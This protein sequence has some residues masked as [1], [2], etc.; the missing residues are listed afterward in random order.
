M[1]AW[2]MRYTAAIGGLL[3]IIG[4]NAVSRADDSAALEHFEKRIRPVLVEHCYDCHSAAAKEVKGGLVVDHRDGLRSGGD[5]GPAIVPGKPAESLLIA[6]LKHD[7][8]VMPPKKKLSAVVVSDF[9]TWIEQGAVDPRDE[10]T[11]PQV[12][13]EQARADQY[14]HRRAWWSLQP[15]RKSGVPDVRHGDWPADEIDR[16]LLARLEAAQLLPSEPADPTTLVRRLSF[17]LTGLP[18]TPDDIDEF[19]ADASPDAWERLVDRGLASPHFGERWAR[20]WMDIV[21]YTDTYGY[22]WDIPAKGAWRYRDYLIR[23]FNADVPF[24]Q[25][26]REQLA[27]DLLTSPRINDVEQINESLIGPMFY[28]LGEKRHGDSSEFDGI[29]QEMLDNKV[30][31]CSKAFL[32]LTVSCARCHDHK[33]DAVL[34]TEYYAIGGSFM[35]SRWVAN[36]VDLPSRHAGWVQQLRQLKAELKPLLVTQWQHDL[37]ATT[38][39]TLRERRKASGEKEPA[40][41]DPLSV[42]SAMLVGEA[43]G[44]PFE[45]TW[46]AWLASFQAERKTRQEKNAG[47]FT[48]LADFRDGVPPGW[49]VDGVGLRDITPRGDFTV[50]LNGDQAVGQI[51]PGGLFTFADSPRLNGTLRSPLLN[52]LEPG[53]LSFEVCGGEFAARRSVIDNAFLCEKQAYLNQKHVAWQMMD[54]FGS[55]RYRHIYHEFATKASN[56]NFP[57]RWGLGPL[58]S[59][60]QMSDPTSRLGITQ[61]VHPQAAFTPVDELSL[62]QRLTDGPAPASLDELAKKYVTVGLNVLERW[63]AG[64]MDDD[65]VRLL[66][67]LIEQNLISNRRDIPGTAE[68]VDRYRDVE[69]RMPAPW[70]VNGMAEIDPG[71]DLPLLNRGEY[72]QFG[73]PVPRGFVQALDASPQGYGVPTSGRLELAE[74]IASPRNPLTSRVMVNRVWHWLFGTGL[75]ATPSDFG[76]AGDL[77]SHPQL[78]DRL[79]SDFSEEQW[80]LKRT[81]R[82]IVN[83]RVWRQSSRTTEAALAA[84]PAN[85]WLHHYPLRRLEAEAIR[86]ALLVTSGRFDAALYG[87]PINPFRT[88]EDAMKRLFTGPVDGN[89]R[90]SIYAKVTI[91]EP[92]KFLAAFNQPAPKIPTGLRDITNTPAQA[93]VLLNDPLVKQQAEYW[94]VHLVQGGESQPEL[95][96]AEMFRA[97]LGRPPSSEEMERWTSAA[98]ELATL[99]QVS[100]D[101]WLT[102][103]PVWTDLAHAL[104]NTKEFLYGL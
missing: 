53:Q 78:L 91:M 44:K 69:R 24:D 40:I 32:A 77:P 93:L 56:P 89:G 36:T 45:E 4:G 46:A 79:A 11:N 58:L 9:E 13:N 92:P 57:P 23:A 15:I 29:H 64:K 16:F 74:A 75:V 70:T 67:W 22:E 62:I 90:R 73:A 86:D 72:D 99:H 95:R 96:I 37:Q 20:H 84:D 61:V 8:L 17:A 102:S 100:G 34:Q 97:A 49:S 18:P 28:Q 50:T 33:L 80:S 83:S 66:N 60:E 14:N 52:S 12:A 88:N 30:D 65:D 2:I 63:S 19:L 82:R 55:M 7:G 42:W 10:A 31:A 54:V 59:E 103:V 51:L 39:E 48:V 5:S 38:G 27:G 85:R 87:E 47:Q 43:A 104:F 6:A 21:R 101:Q 25:L 71:F 1:L 76:H 68:L 3:L 98:R 81:V 35:S 94:A 26:I 41:E